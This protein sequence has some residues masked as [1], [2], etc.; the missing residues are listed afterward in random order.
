MTSPC[1][2]CDSEVSLY[3]ESVKPFR[4]K[5]FRCFSCGLVQMDEKFFLNPDSEKAVYQSHENHNKDP[6]YVE[7]L[8][9]C[10]KPTLKHVSSGFKG[11]DYG[12]GPCS[13]LAELMREK[14]FAMDVY[15]PFFFPEIKE[16]AY[17][18]V[19]ATEVVEHFNHPLVS[20]RQMVDRVKKGGVLSVMTSILYSSVDFAGWHYRRDITHVSFYSPKTFKWIANRLDLAI[21]EEMRN[22][23]I[24]RKN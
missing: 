22:V 5:Y 3:F 10:L 14:G 18:F 1:R 20:W 11:L 7:F 13:I 19:T 12:C 8:N 23:V 6:G 9:Q 4:A 16:E 21:L 2:L 17:A 24:F 15:D